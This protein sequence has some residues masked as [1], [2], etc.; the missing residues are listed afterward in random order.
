MDGS[1]GGIPREQVHVYC[2]L[3]MYMY[4]VYVA[5]LA[6][7]HYYA[8]CYINSESIQSTPKIGKHE[9]SKM[10]NTAISAHSFS[11]GTNNNDETQH[12]TTYMH[13]CTCTITQEYYV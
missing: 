5:R 12:S 13:T 2:T 8:Q 6:A 1:Q 10:V 7:M 9:T 4:N 11:H 3:Y